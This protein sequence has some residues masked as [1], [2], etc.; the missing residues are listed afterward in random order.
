[1]AVLTIWGVR[2]KVRPLT[3]V[4]IR[5]TQV[6]DTAMYLGSVL[7]RPWSSICNFQHTL[8]C[9]NMKGIIAWTGFNNEAAC[10][11]RIVTRPGDHTW[12]SFAQN[13]EDSL[14]HLSPL[15][16]SQLTLA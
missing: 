7:T 15:Y 3:S 11:D 12:Q 16:L 6:L 4:G 14:C 8:R 9:Q 5:L 1:M 10:H 2:L 13:F